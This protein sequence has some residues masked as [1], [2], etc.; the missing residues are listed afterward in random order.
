M[1]LEKWFVIKKKSSGLAIGS[2]IPT[3]CQMYP[4]VSRLQ[5]FEG[6]VKKWFHVLKYPVV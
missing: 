6:V 3:S 5:M 1:L 2:C 4:V